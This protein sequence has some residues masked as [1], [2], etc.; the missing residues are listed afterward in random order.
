MRKILLVFAT[1]VVFLVA[2]FFAQL[3]LG[4]V[5]ALF[6]WDFLEQNGEK[7]PHSMALSWVSSNPTVSRLSLPVGDREIKADLYYVQDKEKRAAILLTHGIIATGKDDPRLVRFASSLARAGFIVLIPEIKGM[8]SLRLLLSDVDDIVA[9]FRFLASLGDQVDVDKM[10]LLGFSLGA[11]PTAMAASHPSVRSQVEFLVLFGGY[12]DPINVI[13]FV[14]TGSYEYRGEEG[15]HKPEPYGKKVFFLNNLDYVESEQDQRTLKEIFTDEALK[16]N[17]TTKEFRPLLRPLS[18]EGLALYELLINEDP[19]RVEGL[20][21]RTDRRFQDYL[22]QISM[23]RVIPSVEAHLIIGHGTSDPLV[24]YTESLRL[25]D[26]VKDKGKVHLAILNLFA[27]VDPSQKRY[28]I[29]D[30]LTVH[31]PSIFHFYLLI[32]DLLSQQH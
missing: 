24:P 30:Y 16:R 31:L 17:K 4:F 14:T 10:G 26:A 27:H 12:F 5:S 2:V 28:S 20:I 29:K 1:L 19:K 15:K 9:S 25:A 7:K 22:D 18:P 3:R 11:G 23:V 8:K 32:Y 6:I 21:R 13:R